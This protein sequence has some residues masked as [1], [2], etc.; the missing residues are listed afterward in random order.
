MGARSWERAASSRPTPPPPRPAYRSPHHHRCRSGEARPGPRGSCRDQRRDQQ[1]AGRML[2]AGWARTAGRRGGCGGRRRA[3]G[4]RYRWWSRRGLC[5][6]GWRG[7]GTRSGAGRGALWRGCGGWRRSGTATGWSSTCAS[8]SRGRGGAGPWRGSLRCGHC[9]EGW[10]GR[11][12]GRGSGPGEWGAASFA[13]FHLRHSSEARVRGAGGAGGGVWRRS[14][15]SS[16][17]WA[18][19]LARAL[20]LRPAPRR[21]AGQAPARSVRRHA[22]RRTGA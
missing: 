21:R 15:G 10:S 22:R 18:G 17:A 13:R 14:S 9:G 4:R 12:W 1:G 19:L 6:R 2:V 16:R 11:M 5:V 3:A 7:W 8:V 20:P